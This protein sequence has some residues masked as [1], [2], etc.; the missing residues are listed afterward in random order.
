MAFAIPLHDLVAQRFGATHVAPGV[1]FVAL[2]YC[3]GNTGRALEIHGRDAH[4]I[5][6]GTFRVALGR[7]VP[8]GRIVIN[9]VIDCV[10][11]VFA[12]RHF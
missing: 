10:E 2:G 3:L 5:F 8:A 4:A 12:I 6:K 9:S 11:V 1:M 7:G